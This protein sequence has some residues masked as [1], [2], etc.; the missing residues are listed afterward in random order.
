[1]NKITKKQNEE[2]QIQRLAAQRE[3]YNSAKRLYITQ[4]VFSVVIPIILF[5]V[6]VFISSI[7][8]YS[9][10]FGLFSFFISNLVLK[11][12]IISSKK[13]G[14]TIQE[15]FDCDVLEMD[16]SPLRTV[17]D[18]QI[19]EIL[20]RYKAYCKID[21][22][23]EKLKNWYPIIVGELPISI[24]RILCQRAN[25]WWDSNLRKKYS[26]TI[27]IIALTIL[28]I[29]FIY[30]FFRNLSIVDITL[31]LSGLIPFFQFCF[32]EVI[33]NKNSADKLTE[34]VNYSKAIWKYSINN[35][36]DYHSHKQNSRR[37]QDEIFEH[38]SN[39]SLI[40]NWVYNLYRNN[41]EDLMNKSSEILFEEAKE[42]LKE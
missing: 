30:S 31:L 33:G 20:L 7:L 36:D 37:L 25:C 9:A 1:M 18:I 28:S 26:T 5:I 10:L 27:K 42:A 12:A 17:D 4:I 29:I 32:D 39:A 8:K 11:K 38:R 14:A 6:S 13:K 19:E 16:N 23:A 21:N 15:L 41:D 3:V 40:L 24:G 22:D 2:K 34:L 35:P